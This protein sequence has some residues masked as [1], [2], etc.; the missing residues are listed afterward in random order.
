MSRI[1]FSTAR[2]SGLMASTAGDGAA[3]AGSGLGAG[4]GCGPLELD[5]GG[6]VGA[7]FA[8]SC[9]VRACVDLRELGPE[10]LSEY[11]RSEEDLRGSEPDSG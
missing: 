7:L 1:F 11:T 6:S 4:R 5:R 8:S 2:V 3:F 10:V 9:G